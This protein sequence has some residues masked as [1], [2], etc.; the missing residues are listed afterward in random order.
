MKL[1]DC[2]ILIIDDTSSIRAYLQQTLQ[3]LGINQVQEAAT[4]EQGLSLFKQQH[5]DIVFLDIELPDI[6]GRDLL[7]TIKQHTP[8]VHV[9]MITAHNTVEN[10]QQSIT[11]G[12]SGFVAKPFSIQKIKNIIE[13]C[14]A[15]KLS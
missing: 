1:S 12:A 4:G 10:L 9:V 13:R 2:S 7:G 5:C 14:M 15:A 11:A 3:L 8:W 6:N